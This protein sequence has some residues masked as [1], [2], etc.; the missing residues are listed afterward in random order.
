MF[1]HCLATMHICRNRPI[2]LLF[3]FGLYRAISSPLA[4]FPS[5]PVQLPAQWLFSLWVC[6]FQAVWAIPLRVWA[7]AFP[8]GPNNTQ[9]APCRPCLKASFSLQLIL[10]L[11]K[12][13]CRWCSGP[14]YHHDRIYIYPVVGS[15]PHQALQMLSTY[16]VPCSNGLQS[17]VCIGLV[18]TILQPQQLFPPLLHQ[19]WRAPCW[20]QPLCTIFGLHPLGYCYSYN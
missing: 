14:P 18:Q 19:Q 2:V 17:F 10:G 3:P 7:V 9:P 20:P 11:S 5:I 4:R 8:I 13:G 1:Q 16:L 6:L 15:T 12:S